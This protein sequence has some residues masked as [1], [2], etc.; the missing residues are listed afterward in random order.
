[1]I[2]MQSR[3]CWTAFF[4]IDAVGLHR[5]PSLKSSSW[6]VFELTVPMRTP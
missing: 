6:N 1:M 2:S 3:L 4:R 5:L